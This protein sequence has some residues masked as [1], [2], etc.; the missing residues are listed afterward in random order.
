MEIGEASDEISRRLKFNRRVC[1][2]TIII[3]CCA[4]TDSFNFV[5]HE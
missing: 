4:R 3:F 2:E 1:L 5:A